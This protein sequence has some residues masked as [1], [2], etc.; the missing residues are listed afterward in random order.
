MRSYSDVKFVFFLAFLFFGLYSCTDDVLYLK[1]H[2]F[3]DNKWGKKEKPVF[4][5][6]FPEDDIVYD[7][8]FTVRTTTDYRYDNMW[9]YITTSGPECEKSRSKDPIL[10]KVP[11]EIKLAK[12]NG[13]WI[14]EKSGTYVETQMLFRQRKFCK[15][16]YTFQIE[17][18]VT[19]D[20]LQEVSDITIEV[21]PKKS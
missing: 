4:K 16:E 5:V 14:G 18:G 9:W 8:I 2:S 21:K 6:N 13:E 1:T 11:V 12:A 19:M 10:G 17:Q 20:V 15:G 7:I 3:T